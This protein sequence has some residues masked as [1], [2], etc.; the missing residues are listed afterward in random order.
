M[1]LVPL[2]VFSFLLMIVTVIGISSCQKELS[3]ENP[4]P[5]GTLAKGSLKDTSGNCLPASVNGTW[6]NGV[7]AGDTNFVTIKVRVT[8]VGNYRIS[9]DLQNGVTLSDS[10]AFTS[11]GL[12]TVHLKASGTF[13]NPTT[14]FFTINFDAS[15]C[16]FA[17][18]VKD[19][20]GTGLG[21][22]PGGGNPGG[23][24]TVALNTWQFEVNGHVYQGNVNAAQ[25]SSQ[26]GPGI[27]SLVGSMKSLPPGSMP[28]TTFAIGV[29]FSA[30]A[31]AP[32]TYTT[33]GTSYFLFDLVPSGDVIFAANPQPASPVLSIVITSYDASSKTVT[34][35]FSGNSYNI[36]SQTVPIINGAF[37]SKVPLP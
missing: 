2:S 18:N 26:L 17:V 11:I 14:T 37:K 32:G 31:I 25:F 24:G 20:T 12:T 23:G 16:Q 35:T 19:S 5:P 10:G 6:Y 27:L 4:F 15:A 21:G 34:G 13:L 36:S 33:D 8:S 9:T 7:T 29:T 1:R 22:N 3:L 30:A 28:D